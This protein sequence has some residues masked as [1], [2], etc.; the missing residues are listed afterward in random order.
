V[1]PDALKVWLPEK[2]KVLVGAL[3]RLMAILKVEQQLPLVM[4]PPP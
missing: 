1:L 3:D 4:V 2:V